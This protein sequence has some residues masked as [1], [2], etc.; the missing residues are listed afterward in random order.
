LLS[1]DVGVQKTQ[2]LHQVSPSPFPCVHLL[3]PGP[4]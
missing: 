3:C 2:N 1:I 4:Q